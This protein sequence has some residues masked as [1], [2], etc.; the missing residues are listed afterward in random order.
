MSVV[1]NVVR[2]V[3]FLL[4]FAFL[5]EQS[6]CSELVVVMFHAVYFYVFW[7]GFLYFMGLS[8]IRVSTSDFVICQ[9]AIPILIYLQK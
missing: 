4:P 7:S 8:T 3:L 6:H 5:M 9:N 2:F 1:L